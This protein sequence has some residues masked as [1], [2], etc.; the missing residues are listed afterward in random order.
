MTIG[1]FLHQL[2]KPSQRDLLLSA[3]YY[4]ERYDDRS[5]V[6]T[7][8]IKAAFGRAKNATG[9]KMQHAAVLNQAV[10]FV[11]SP[12]GKEDGRLLWSLTDSGRKHV[13]GLLNLPEAEAEVETDVA[14]LTQL[15]GGI[16]DAIVKSYIE[17][18]I[19]CLQV[20]ALRASVVFLW[21]GAIARIRDEVWTLANNPTQ[22]DAA[23]KN[24]NP[25]S[26]SFKKKGDFSR[27]NDAALIEIT[28]DL[29]LYD[30]SERK[31]LKEGLDLRNDC[32]HPVKFQ[33][34]TAK[35]RAFI[36]DVIG[37]VF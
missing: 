7:A 25:G 10:P 16:Q 28:E 18:A 3:M 36:E 17:E 15:T 32:G 14:S 33:P 9:K 37:V 21:S 13:R 8:D 19:L 35:V 29:N 11:E 20:G 12:G 2:K 27:V 31:R 23:L 24:H 6:T 4:L 30:K 22:I 26:K 34:G 5:A 1:E